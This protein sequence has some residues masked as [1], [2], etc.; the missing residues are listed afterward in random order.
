LKWRWELKRIRAEHTKLK[1]Y[2][3]GKTTKPNERKM[4]QQPNPNENELSD[5][6][7]NCAQDVIDC[8]F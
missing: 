5:Y 6:E 1:T 2:F 4:F 8:H 3:G 7:L